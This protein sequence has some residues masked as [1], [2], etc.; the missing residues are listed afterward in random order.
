MYVCLSTFVQ[1][2]PPNSLN[3]LCSIF[4]QIF[5]PFFVFCSF[6][7]QLAMFVDLHRKESWPVGILRGSS[8]ERVALI[9]FSCH[10]DSQDF[11]T[12]KAFWEMWIRYALS[13][14]LQDCSAMGPIHSSIR[15]DE[16]I[17]TALYSV[18][19]DNLI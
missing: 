11:Q 9:I 5:Y 17:Q 19:R 7:F 4:Q 12:I 16:R 6:W 14:R 3:G 2:A 8:S 13:I 15:I 1:L 10:I 18:K